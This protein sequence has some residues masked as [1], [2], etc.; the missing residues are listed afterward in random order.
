[1]FNP[2][3]S[4][5]QDYLMDIFNFNQTLFFYLAKIS[6]NYIGQLIA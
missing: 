1:M 5:D 4:T 6:N 2:I 3:F